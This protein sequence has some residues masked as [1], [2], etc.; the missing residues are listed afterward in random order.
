MNCEKEE[1]ANVF[2]RDK[3]IPP[4]D[5]RRFIESWDGQSLAPIRTFAK[6]IK[7]A[8]GIVVGRLQHDKR[9]PNSHGNGLKVFYRWSGV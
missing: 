1:E 7:I 9:L 4:A 5:Y 6:K 3:L 2:A 8:P